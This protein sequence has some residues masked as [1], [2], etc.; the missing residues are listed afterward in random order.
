MSNI[1]SGGSRPKIANSIQVVAQIPDAIVDTLR[2][3]LEALK[4]ELRTDPSNYAPGRGSA[5]LGIEWSLKDRCFQSSGVW[6]DALWEFCQRINPGCQM[7][8]ITH[9]GNDAAGKGIGL[10]RDDSYAEFETRSLT[11]EANNCAASTWQMR[12]TYPGMTWS[13]TQDMDAPVHEFSIPS[14]TV[15][16][17]NCKNPHAAHP[18]PDRWSLNLWTV[19]KKHAAA[20]QAYIAEHGLSGGATSNIPAGYDLQLPDPLII[21]DRQQLLAPT[22]RAILPI[23]EVAQSASP[24][25]SASFSPATALQISG[26]P[27]QMVFKLRLHNHKNPLP[28]D[29]CFEAMRG[30]GRTHTTRSFE[31]YT[32]YNIKQGDVAIAYARDQKIAIRVGEQYR[33]TPAMIADPDYQQRWSAQEKHHTDELQTFWDK[34]AW[35]LNFEPLGDYVDGQIIPFPDRAAEIYS[36]SRQE[37]LAWYTVAANRKDALLQAEIIRIGSQLKSVFQHETGDIEGKPPMN[38]RHP[39]VVMSADDRH[40]MDQD[41]AIDS[42]SNGYHPSRAEL[43]AWCAAA[44]QVMPERVPQIVRIGMQ[45]TS[46]Y[47][48]ETNTTHT[49]PLDYQHPCVVMAERDLQQMQQDVIGAQRFLER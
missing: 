24:K 30:Y 18:N 47:Q 20:Y 44:Q 8:L 49:P 34:P 40:Q 13:K 33:I 25:A 21:H 17:F 2:A 12:Q 1:G 31:P 46:L 10:H 42:R 4:P 32:C 23:S 43:R 45:L 5:W 27:I 37:L 28:V 16:G 11:I 36:P 26:K 22:I 6:D 7:V 9:S 41:L 14:G 35:G 15:I 3:R 39:Q 29:T 19:S 48:Q 38:Y